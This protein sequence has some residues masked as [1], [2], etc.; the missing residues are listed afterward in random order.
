M[1]IN[2]PKIELFENEFSNLLGV[3]HSLTVSSCT[4]ALHMA[5]I[6]LNIKKGDEVIVPSLTFAATA[7]VIKYVGAKPVFCDVLSYKDLTIDPNDILKKVSK[8]QKQL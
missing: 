2:R 8:R 7:N 4:A 6:S 5:L 1:D 3:K